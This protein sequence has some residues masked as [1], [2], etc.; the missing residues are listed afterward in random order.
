MDSLNLHGLYTLYQTPSKFFIQPCD[1]L[2][3]ALIINRQNCEITLNQ[4]FS[5]TF[6]PHDALSYP[7]QGLI[8][9][10][11][12][13]GN[14]YLIVIKSSTHVGSIAGHHIYKV[15]K[16]EVIPFRGNSHQKLGSHDTQAWENIYVNMLDSVLETPNFYFSQTYDLTNSLQ[17][18]YQ[19]Y[20]ASLAGSY[21]YQIHGYQ[22]YDRRFLWNGHLI[23]DLDRLGTAASRYRLPLIMG[24]IY[25]GE[26]LLGSNVNWI[27]ASR[28]SVRRAGTRFNC[29]G[30]DHEG[31][32]ANFVETE[33]ILEG[34][35]YTTSFMQI[36]GSIPLIWSQKPKNYKYKPDI[37]IHN[38][39]HDLAMRKH[40]DELK[41]TYGDISL[42]SLIDSRG[43]EGNLGHQ[44]SDK[45][46]NIGNVQYH[47]FD[48]HKECSKMRWHR[49][50]IL[51]DR[52]EQEIG[53]YGFFATNGK[54]VLRR[55]TG[56][57]RSNCIDCLDRTNVVQSMVA[58]TV[59]QMQFNMFGSVA[60]G[61]TISSYP[62]FMD[63][64]NNV[65]A[66]NADAISIQY[67][68]T[69]A[70]KT[71]FTR[72]GQRTH[73]GMLK[74]GLNSMTRYVSNNFLDNYRQ[75]A[76]DLFLGHFQGYPSPLYRP[77][78]LVSYTSRFSVTIFALVL[79]A[80]YVYIRWQ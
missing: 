56:V 46:N 32:V 31:N 75:D 47:Y 43:H 17:R 58:Q 79:I 3:E 78:E 29:R 38:E 59:L 51:L 27:L 2:E 9:I 63:K 15:D 12:L 21:S 44:F 73:T 6:L 13:M 53:A 69:P 50:S 67:A 74:D 41:A 30:A 26:N 70:L 40:I 34:Y 76:I 20:A 8:G 7:I 14:S 66:D 52:L 45:I 35:G 71:D 54:D 5:T 39:N 61:L 55:Q 49:L 18:N 65:W 24:F 1:E 16:T 23:Q 19:N 22:Y 72:T 57:I 11:H 4:M 42:V 28:R 68:G 25:I 64:F 48:F 80:L 77:S 33:Q 10:K 36:R 62:V 60:R 37:E